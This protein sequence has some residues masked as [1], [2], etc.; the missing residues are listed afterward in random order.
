M[1]VLWERRHGGVH[2]EVRSAGKTLRLYSNGVLHTQFNPSRLLTGSVW[3][4]ML[5]GALT[6]PREQVRRVLMLGVGGGAVIR[7]LLAVFPQVEI[8]GIELN[9]VHL[10]V[11]RRFFGLRDE[12]VQLHE[13]NAVTWLALYDG[14]PFDLIIDD[15][16]GERGGAPCRAVDADADWFD[17]LATHLADDGVLVMNF[18]EGAEVRA[19]DWGQRGESARRFPH[20]LSLSTPTCENRVV[21]FSPRAVSA[22]GLALELRDI[23][24]IRPSQLR[25]RARELRSG[26]K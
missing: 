21:T 8:T 1:A 9:P 14:E 4:L 5:L 7:Q 11:A 13:D 17:L 6:L 24:A 23:P 20:A 26:R 16:F 18:A 12:R 15:L 10:G 2:Y 22:A 25:Y 19:S 3:D